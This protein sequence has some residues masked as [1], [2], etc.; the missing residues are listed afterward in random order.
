MKIPS[1]KIYR[2]TILSKISQ[3]HRQYTQQIWRKCEAILLMFCER[4]F[5]VVQ[6]CIPITLRVSAD[7][8]ASGTSSD[9]L[10]AALRDRP[11]IG[12]EL[13]CEITPIADGLKVGVET[14]V[15]P[16]QG[17][18]VAIIEAGESGLWISEATVDRRGVTLRAEVEMVPPTAQ[19]F[20]LA[21]SNVR[22]T[23]LAGGKAVEALGCD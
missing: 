8:P 13:R 14:D 3:L 15:P 10:D 11:T 7:L 4:L 21:R 12:G 5:Q 19:P 2:F 17:E 22:L 6:I 9:A 16:M 1:N 18:E 20:A 23:V